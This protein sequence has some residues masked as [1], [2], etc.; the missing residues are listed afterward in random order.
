MAQSS[1][2][3]VIEAGAATA[4]GLE[5]RGRQAALHR[6]HALEEGGP[7]GGTGGAAGWPGSPEREPTAWCRARSAAAPFSE[8]R[9]PSSSPFSSTRAPNGFG[10]DDFI[11]VTASGQ[12]PRRLDELTSVLQGA[13][14]RAC[15]RWWTARPPRAPA[16][17]ARDHRGGP[18]V[19]V[20]SARKHAAVSVVEVLD[21][22]PLAEAS[23]SPNTRG[24]YSGALRRL[25]RLARRRV[26][27]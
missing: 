19:A 16:T 3:E 20:G 12:A 11:E 5:R 13:G 4:R 9:P 23:L 22:A 18:P 24:A 26:R 1:I 6:V 2:T 17:A 15:P 10:V 7:P 25:G 27:T 21:A 8:P 14:Q